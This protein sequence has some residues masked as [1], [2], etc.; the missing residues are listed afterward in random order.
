MAPTFDAY[1]SL[2]ACMT[3]AAAWV[4]YY[5]TTEAEMIQHVLEDLEA[6]GS[7][8][9]RVHLTVDHD[10][11]DRYGPQ[12]DLYALCV[13]TKN[14]RD[15][16]HVRLYHAE[17]WYGE[18]E[19]CIYEPWKTYLFKNKMQWAY[20]KH[21][22]SGSSRYDGHS[23]WGDC[24]DLVRYLDK[25]ESKE[26]RLDRLRRR[27]E[28]LRLVSHADYDIPDPDC[29]DDS[30]AATSHGVCPCGCNDPHLL[31]QRDTRDCMLARYD[32]D[33]N[34]DCDSHE[35]VERDEIFER[36]RQRRIERRNEIASGLYPQ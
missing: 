25:L 23:E 19:K 28:E 8:T 7:F 18:H 9:S 21:F 24:F 36:I 26:H 33:T 3:K 15:E 29:G 22:M 12:S 2:S 11:Y 14:Q 4:S 6:D 35:W 1:S 13:W 20:T 31:R 32:P 17:M 16:Y 27:A 5:N 30:H 34:I 10:G